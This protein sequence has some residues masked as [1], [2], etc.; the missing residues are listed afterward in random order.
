MGVNL[1]YVPKMFERRFDFAAPNTVQIVRGVGIARFFRDCQP[2]K[3]SLLYHPHEGNCMDIWC[4][5]VIEDVSSFP[6]TTNSYFASGF[7]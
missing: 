5:G 6:A 2:A 4:S 1:P 3:A 7:E